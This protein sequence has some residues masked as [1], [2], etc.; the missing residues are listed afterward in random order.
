VLGSQCPIVRAKQGPNVLSCMANS[1]ARV[2]FAS[3]ET[4]M[5]MATEMVPIVL[6]CL[7]NGTKGIL[8]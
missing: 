1:T 6:L 4:T 3:L 2:G 7:P 8:L 5:S